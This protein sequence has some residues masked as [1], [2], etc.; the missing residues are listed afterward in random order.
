MT[1]VQT[2]IVDEGSTQIKVCWQDAVSGEFQIK[3]IPSNVAM[4]EGTDDYGKVLDSSYT[5]DGDDYYVFGNGQREERLDTNTNRYQVS[6]ANLVLL[7]EALRQAGFGGKSVDVF[8]TLPVDQYFHANG[9]SNDERIKLKK[10]RLMRPIENSNGLPLADIKSIGVASESIPA[11]Y[12]IQIDDNLDADEEQCELESVLVVDIGGTTTDVSLINGDAIV[13]KR[14]TIPNGVY[15]IESNIRSNLVEIGI[16][17]VSD[18]QMYH[19]LRTKEFRGQDVTAE[20][21]KSIRSIQDRIATAMVK[22]EDKPESLDCI[23]IVGGGA[24]LFG[25]SLAD[26]YADGQKCNVI[27]PENPETYVAKGLMKSRL[28]AKLLLE[29]AEA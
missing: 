26:L 28:Y 11:W 18:T 24:A 25:Q 10:D 12:N 3:I 15:D 22:F 29:E 9:K 4:K 13:S 19:L 7:H 8:V 1:T 20:V 23:L 2:V 14:G 21:R 16:R 5:L 6:N 17:S 27:I